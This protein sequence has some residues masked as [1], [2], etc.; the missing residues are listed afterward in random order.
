MAISK[1]NKTNA[2][3][4]KYYRE[5]KDYREEKIK[6]RAREYASDKKG[7]AKKS[8]EYYW[9]NPQ[10]RRYKINYA[11]QYRKTHKTKKTK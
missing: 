11:R 4:R 3:A 10:Y 5:N 1:R 9:D 8:R 6:D 7:E 2:Y